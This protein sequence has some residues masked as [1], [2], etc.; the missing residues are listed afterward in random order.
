MQILIFAVTLKF[1]FHYLRHK[2]EIVYITAVDFILFQLTLIEC[3][4]T[5]EH[6]YENIFTFI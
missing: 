3:N 2:T 6:N 1:N 5:F 4:Y